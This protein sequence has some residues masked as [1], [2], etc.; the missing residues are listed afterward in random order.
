MIVG[1]PWNLDW[2]N[3]NADSAYAANHVAFGDTVA[4]TNL[5][6]PTAWSPYFGVVAAHGVIEGYY[7]GL[8]R[9]SM[10]DSYM[11]SVLPWPLHG[12]EEPGLNT[13]LFEIEEE[14]GFD[15]GYHLAQSMYPRTVFSA[16]PSYSE[17]TDP[18][19]AIGYP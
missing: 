5:E 13:E 15:V 12:Q 8:Q 17:Q 2:R 14:A 16:P 3:E 11:G 6:N 1:A 10:N 19:P 4:F 18:I 9:E 7:D